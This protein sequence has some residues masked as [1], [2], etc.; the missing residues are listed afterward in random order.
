[1]GRGIALALERRASARD[2]AVEVLGRDATPEAL[3]EGVGAAALVLVATP[4]DAVRDA[5][6]ALLATGKVGPGHAVLHLSGFL[7]HM[8]L[9]PLRDT[10]AALGSFHPLQTVAEASSAPERLA[11]SYAAVEGDRAAVEAAVALAEALGMRVVHLD[12]AAKPLYHAAATMA[13]NYTVTL[14]GIAT[15]L[16][17]QAGLEVEVARRIF[18]PL[19]HGVVANVEELGA[20]AALTGPVRRGDVRTIAAHLGALDADDQHLYRLL[21]LET[22]ALAREGGLD[23]TKARHVEAELSDEP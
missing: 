14:V 15:R 18:L 11:G 1:M 17:E 22:L 21:G 5:A 13:G 2:V 10:G 12:A 19:V 20:A 7:D 3:A 16:A 6:R 8:A 4:D 9:A 23:A